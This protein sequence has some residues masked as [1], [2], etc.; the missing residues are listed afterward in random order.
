MLNSFGEYVFTDNDGKRITINCIRRRQE[1]NCRKLG[2]Y[3]KSL[4]KIRKTYGTI[5]LDH[6]IDNCLIME[7]MG[8][9]DIACTGLIG[10][11]IGFC[12]VMPHKSSKIKGF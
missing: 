2:I 5:L 6:N 10:S 1:R 11:L 7:Q 8:H 9:T 12:F 4:H 3:R